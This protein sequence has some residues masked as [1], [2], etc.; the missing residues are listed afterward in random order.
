MRSTGTLHLISDMYD[1]TTVYMYHKRS[2]K[3][4]LAD[5]PVH[6]KDKLMPPPPPPNPEWLSDVNLKYSL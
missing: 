6:I 4:S 2:N 1:A 5:T 3:G